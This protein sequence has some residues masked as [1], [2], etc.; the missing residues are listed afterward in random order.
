MFV[1]FQNGRLN[2]LICSEVIVYY[3]FKVFFVVLG[4]VLVF[5]YFIKLFNFLLVNGCLL[6]SIVQYVMKL[7][8]IFLNKVVKFGYLGCY[9]L[10]LLK[11]F[12]K[13]CVLELDVL[14]LR[15]EICW[16]F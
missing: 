7:Q 2:S 12:E 9:N 13:M 16:F 10:V 4:D 15:E 6:V 14:N 1:D 8:C 5:K 3:I 11:V